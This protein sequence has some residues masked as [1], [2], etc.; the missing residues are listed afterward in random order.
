MFGEIKYKITKVLGSKLEQILPI[1][2]R[3]VTATGGD[4]LGR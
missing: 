1:N 4:R 3:R 2:G